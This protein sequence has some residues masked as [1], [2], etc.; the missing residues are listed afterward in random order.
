MENTFNVVR[1]L[2]AKKLEIDPETILTDSKLEDLGLDSLDVF[3]IIFEA[4]DKYGIKVP[5]PTEEIATVQD[6]VNM[7]NKLLS[8]KASA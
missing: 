3:D 5:N 1:D 4:E 7:L 2:I 8:D 6:V